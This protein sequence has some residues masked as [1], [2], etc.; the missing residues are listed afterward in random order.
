MAESDYADRQDSERRSLRRRYALLTIGLFLPLL[1]SFFLTR[2]VYPAASWTVMMSGGNLQRPW[3][4]Y[5]VRGET[6]GGAVVDVEPPEL[7]NALYGRNWSLVGAAVNNEP[8]KLRSLHPQNKLL[9][10]TRGDLSQL[11]RGL[12]VPELLQV[13]GNLYNARLAESSPNR[14][15]AVRI[16]VYRWDSGGY[17]DYDRF[18]ETWRHEL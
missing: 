9:L 3:T 2:N 8:F 16:D 7:I 6:V 13:W 12:R 11:P 10:A 4:Y 1:T 17:H 18:V 14:L 15:K 5:L